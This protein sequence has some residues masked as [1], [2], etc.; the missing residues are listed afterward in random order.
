MISRIFLI[1]ICKEFVVISGVGKLYFI[2]V[3]YHDSFP[4]RKSNSLPLIITDSEK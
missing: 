3:T 2:T 1:K 4:H